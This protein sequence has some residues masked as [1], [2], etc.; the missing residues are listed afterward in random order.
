MKPILQRISHIGRLF[1]A[2]S[3]VHPARDW[4]ILLGTTAVLIGGV[5]GWNAWV[6]METTSKMVTTN[7]HA[8]I[9]NFDTSVVESVQKAF[10]IRAQEAERYRSTYH[11]VDPSR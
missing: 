7:E 4:F 2:G 3:H 11:F 8:T 9:P 1:H 6:Y 5:A 10:A